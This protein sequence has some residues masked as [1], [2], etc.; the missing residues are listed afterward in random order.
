MTGTVEEIYIAATG[1][2]AMTPV[3]GI[4]AVANAGLTGDRYIERRG[5]WSG[6]DECQVT[7]IE[8]EALD[9]ITAETDLR[10]N[11]G[12]HRRNIVTRGIRLL[13]LKGRTFRIGTAVM[14]YDRPRPPCRYIQEITQ[15]GMTRALSR[16]RGGICVRVIQSGI[17]RVHDFIVVEP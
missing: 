15:E 16:G 8:R 7:L 14:A 13:D 17:I 3:T 9:A 11:G 6:I 10:I 2:R 4:E 12:E 1:G 5:H